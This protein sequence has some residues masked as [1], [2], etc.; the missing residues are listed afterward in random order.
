[1][2]G[3]FHE[4]AVI[5]LDKYLRPLPAGLRD[6]VALDQSL[7]DIAFPA[8]RDQSRDFANLIQ[9][10]A[11]SPSVCAPRHGVASWDH[12]EGRRAL[13]QTKRRGRW[14]SPSS[15]KR[16]A[17]EAHLQD[18]MTRAPGWAFVFGRLA[19]ASLLE[20]VEL[21]PG[22]Q[23]CPRFWQQL[24]EAAQALIA[25]VASPAPVRRHREALLAQHLTAARHEM[26]GAFLKF[27]AG[28]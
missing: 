19:H 4:S 5:D 12:V 1:K 24:P 23:R 7:C 18:A 10:Q 14:V 2:K 17:K 6:A 27:C 28:S 13:G 16:F 20:I 11:L 26:F 15:M 9:L 3:L 8:L 25:A 22:L 21:G